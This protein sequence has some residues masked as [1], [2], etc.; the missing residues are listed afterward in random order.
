MILRQKFQ[1]LVDNRQDQNEI[2]HNGDTVNEAL[3]TSSS[4]Q[5]HHQQQQHEIVSISGYTVDGDS[6]IIII[7]STCENNSFSNNYSIT[8]ES[9]HLQ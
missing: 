9:R 5:Q 2:H 4:R 8:F 6:I 1:K 3:N 7:I